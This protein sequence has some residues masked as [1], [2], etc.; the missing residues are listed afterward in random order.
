MQKDTFTVSYVTIVNEKPEGL[1]RD[2]YG[3]A[4]P[5]DTGSSL[6]SPWQ[7]TE[8]ETTY[9]TLCQNLEVNYSMHTR[10]TVLLTHT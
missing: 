1:I 10:C 8:M 5:V 7:T 2:N 4:H 9:A 6:M 3:P